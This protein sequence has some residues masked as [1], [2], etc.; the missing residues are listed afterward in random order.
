M[1]D[2]CLNDF[3]DFGELVI[4]TAARLEKLCS[5]TREQVKSFQL[6]RHADV[7][8]RLGTAVKLEILP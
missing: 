1:H 7:A 2:C 3:D 6:V 8:W 5:L 4:W